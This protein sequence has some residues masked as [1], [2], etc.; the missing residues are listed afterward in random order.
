G[1]TI[2]DRVVDE[3]I[4]RNKSRFPDPQA[5]GS[6]MKAKGMTEAD[7]RRDTRKTMAVNR[8]LEGGVL[9]DIHISAEQVRDFYD[10][11]KEEFKHPAQ[12]RASH[13]LLRI[14]ENASAAERAAVTQRAA[15]LVTQLQAGAD[16][17]AFARQ[18]SQDSVTA[19]HGG[20]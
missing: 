10:H 19:P 8:L 2:S 6:V 4:A 15:A 5:F 20:D 18:H 11:N 14:G 12:V 9:K 17:A 13:I 1:I 7:L 3:E 16:F